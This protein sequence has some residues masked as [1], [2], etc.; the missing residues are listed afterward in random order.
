MKKIKKGDYGYIKHQRNIEIIKTIFMLALSFALYR[1]G[2]YS[3]GSNKNYLTLVAVLGC[4]PMAKFAVNAT[5]FTRAKGCSEEVFSFLSGNAEKPWF[6]DLYF[7]T[8]KKNFQVSALYY[9]KKNLIVLTEDTKIDTAS[10]VEHLETVTKN[11]GFENITVKV[12]DDK[13]KFADRLSEL[14]KLEDD[15]KDLTVLK[16]NILSVS[17]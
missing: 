6:Y 8:L 1:I 4:L 11:C 16:D 13:N 3:T 9:K 7:T 15:E 5:L 14:S 2:I 12:F 10:C 17:I